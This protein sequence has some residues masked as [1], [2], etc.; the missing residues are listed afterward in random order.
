MVQRFRHIKDENVISA[1]K[2]FWIKNSIDVVLEHLPISLDQIV[3]CPFYTTGNVANGRQILNG[4]RYLATQD[5][6]LDA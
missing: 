2:C 4:L 6:E 5:F 1:P 3:A